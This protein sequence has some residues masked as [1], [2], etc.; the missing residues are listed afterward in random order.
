MVNRKKQ[1]R[2]EIKANKKIIFFV[3]NYLLINL[4]I[5]MIHNNIKVHETSEDIDSS[6]FSE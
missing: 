6:H 1:K 3:Y 4:D 5:S 2:L